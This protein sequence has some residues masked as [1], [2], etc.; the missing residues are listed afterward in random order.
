M[1]W[2][3]GYRVFL[4][5]RVA[6]LWPAFL[7][8]AVLAMATVAPINS[9]EAAAKAAVNV[10]MLQSLVPLK[11]WY[12]SLNA[13]SWSI[14]TEMFFYVVFPF[15]LL[16]AKR[17]V[18]LLCAV[19]MALLVTMV[20]LVALL[21]LSSSESDQGVTAWGVLYISPITRIAEFL[22]GMAAYQLAVSMHAHSVKWGKL[23]AAAIEFSALAFAFAAMVFFTWLS[24]SAL[25]E[26]APQFSVW[27]R[28]AGPFLAFGLLLA[29]LYGER[30][31]VSGWLK[32]RPLVYLGE[33]SFALYLLHQ[34]VVRWMFINYRAVIEQHVTAAHILYWVISLAGAAMIYHFIE[35]PM[36]SPLRRL[37]SGQSKI[38]ERGLKL[39]T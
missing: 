1:D 19:A 10:F 8:T 2:R 24:N 16:L 34:I 35:Q 11:D 13:V 20:S 25:K 22:A 38:F 36:R 31:P 12:Y 3:V 32:W 29:V 7:A 17:N 14:S 9:A 5:A 30:G 23:R 26:A 6:R 18:A 39:A 37:L 33:I 27:V 4:A 28:V 21:G 15:A